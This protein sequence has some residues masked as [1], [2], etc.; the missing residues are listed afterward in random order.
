MGLY[1]H[2][3]LGMEN[4]FSLVLTL[5]SASHRCCGASSSGTHCSSQDQD[6]PAC[7]CS[8]GKSLFCTSPTQQVHQIKFSALM[9]LREGFLHLQGGFSACLEKLSL[10]PAL[11]S[12]YTTLERA[13]ENE[14]KFKSRFLAKK[15]TLITTFKFPDLQH[16][17]PQ[18][19][20]NGSRLSGL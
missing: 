20:H 3:Q 11:H 4:S 7:T 5:G 12:T 2:E 14:I 18:L 16:T 1:F 6:C 9:N 15:G 19:Q 13:G 8:A 17:A 10:V